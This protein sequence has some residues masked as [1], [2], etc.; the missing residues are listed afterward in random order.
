MMKS[1]RVI[2]LLECVI[3]IVILAVFWRI[4]SATVV[5]EH[6]ETMDASL[7]QVA[8]TTESVDT[9]TSEIDSVSSPAEGALDVSSSSA[10][11]VFSADFATNGGCADHSETDQCDLFTAN[12][13]LSTGAVDSVVQRTNTTVSESYPAWNPNGTVA[14]ASVFQSYTK[15]SVSV[16]NFASGNASTLV[17]SATWPEVSPDGS[18]LLYVTSDTN[19]LMS[20]PLLGGGVSVGASEQLTG[21]S[22]QEDP[23]YSPDGSS[24]VFHQIMSDGAHGTVLDLASGK[25]V[26][27]SDRTGHCAFSGFGSYTVCDNSRGGG[28]FKRTYTNGVLGESSLFISDLKPEQIAVYDD[29]FAQ[30]GGTSFN[31]PTFCGDD[32]HVLVSTSCNMDAAGGVAFS[33]LFLIDLSGSHPIYRPIGKELAEEFGGSGMSS[34]TVDCLK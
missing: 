3:G 31:Y 7:Q 17:A 24:V 33:R 14:Y 16:V 4:R 15:K 26:Q 25:T 19:M 30:C 32:S 13:N 8:E 9:P 34:W 22:H 27:Y 2:V 1:L 29:V 28:L 23:E 12:V 11:I 5:Q 18:A 10:R 20:A 6:S 21:T